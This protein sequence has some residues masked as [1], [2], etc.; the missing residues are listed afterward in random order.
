[1]LQPPP[2]RPTLPSASIRMLL[3]RTTA[4]PVVCWVWPIAQMMNPGRFSAS[5]LATWKTSASGTPVTSVTL[6][7]VRGFI[8]T[9]RKSTRLNSSHS[10]I[11]YA[12][13]CLKKKKKEN[14]IKLVQH[15]REYVRLSCSS[16]VVFQLYFPC[17]DVFFFFND[18]ATTEIYTLSLHDA[19]PIWSEDSSPSISDSATTGCHAVWLLK[20][21]STAH[22]RSIGASMTAERVT[23]IIAL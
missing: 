17:F 20:S 3:A 2:E 15:L 7:G 12:V 6:S 1:M 10:Q 11:S 18:T 13:F 4:F 8:T 16:E 19:L 22:T 14:A 9:D 21:R 23:R 5:V